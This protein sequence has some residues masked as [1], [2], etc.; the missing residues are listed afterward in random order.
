MGMDPR[1][2]PE[3]PATGHGRAAATI[4]L[5][6]RGDWRKRMN[7][8]HG[9][10][11]THWARSLGLIALALSLAILPTGPVESA[12]LSPSSGKFRLNIDTTISWGARMRMEDRDLSIISPFEPAGEERKGTAWS[13]NGDDGNLNFDKGDIVSNTIKATVD[14]DYSYNG[15]DNHAI[16]FFVRGSGFYD[17]VLEDD[18]CDRTELTDE[19]LDWAGSRTELLD[20]YAWWEFPLGNG[21]GEIRAG[22][23]VLN[24]GESTFIQGGLSV[25]NPVD[26]SALRVPGAE[27]REAFRPLGMVWTS[28]DITSNLSFEGFY[29]YE[30]DQI[31]VDPPGTYFSTNDF[32]GPGGEYV[33]LQF[34]SF[35][36]TGQSPF[37]IQPPTDYP[38]MSVPRTDTVEAKDDGQFGLALRWFVP[39]WGGTEFGFYYINYHSR[40]PTINGI[41]GPVSIV[42]E[43]ES[44]GAAAALQVYY[45]LGVPPGVDPEVDALASQASSAAATSLYAQNSNWYTSYPE[46]I[47]MYGISWNAQLGTS[48]VAF[49]GEVSYKQDAPYQVDD[50]EL[51]FAAL[52]PISEFLA[53]TNQVAPGGVGFSENIDGYRLLDSSQLQFTLTR[54]FP[55]VLGADQGV[56]VGEFGFNWVFDMPEKDVLR[57]EA[58]GT[59]TSG[60]PDN[61]L[62]GAHVGKEWERPEH[63]ADD[64][65]WGYRLAGALQY[66][67]AIGAWS[68]RPRFAWQHD[69]DGITPGPGGSFLAGRQALTLGVLADFQAAWQIDL[70]YTQYSGAGRWN[71]INDR[72]FL[73]GFVKYSF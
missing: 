66:N 2:I 6:K 12:D 59:Y 64:F 1:M 47:K 57:F 61:T 51:L 42:P 20:A 52:S 28:L 39:S 24:W 5:A 33:F 43:L 58:E 9:T 30:W 56:L 41:T 17:F 71:L 16:G 45:A 67:N 25:I 40:L 50:V 35:A 44:A 46:D 23:Q 69:V 38:F 7:T 70:S 3:R 72:D 36:D 22:D 11:P 31:V 48:G 26:V 21:R 13:V 14:I 62:F 19:A 54:A 55:N 37:Y 65:S 49:Q 29:Q 18:C 8:T 32:V 10:R 4:L 63:F 68:L 34:A 73:G 27:L 60:N 53:A 15:W